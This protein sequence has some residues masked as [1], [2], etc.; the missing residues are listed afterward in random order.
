MK[1]VISFIDLCQGEFGRRVAY[2]YAD[3]ITVSNVV[4]ILGD[5]LTVLN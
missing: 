3:K 5:A 1:N 4:R 2:T